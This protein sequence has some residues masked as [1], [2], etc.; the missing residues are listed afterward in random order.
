MFSSGLVKVTIRTT[1]TAD[2]IKDFPFKSF[3]KTSAK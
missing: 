2:Q 3:L 1:N